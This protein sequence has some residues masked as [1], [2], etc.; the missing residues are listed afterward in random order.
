[1]KMSKLDDKF[2]NAVEEIKD[3]FTVA[4]AMAK[5]SF[6]VSDENDALRKENKTLMEDLIEFGRHSPGCPY[7][8]NKEYSCNCGWLETYEALKEK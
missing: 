6:S 8:Y 7:Q 1:M 2:N 3:A 4:Q 5:S